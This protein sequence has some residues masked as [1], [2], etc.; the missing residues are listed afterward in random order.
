MTPSGPLRVTNADAL[1]P[2]LL[3]GLAIAELPE[4]MAAE[5]LAD[6]RVA[7]ILTDWS[8]P[9]GGLYFITPSARTRPAKVAALAEFFIQRLSEPAWRS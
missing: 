4:F 9:V 2:M 8:L 1:V 3:E 5:Y 6:G 7:A